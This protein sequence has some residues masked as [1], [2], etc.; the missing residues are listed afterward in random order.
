MICLIKKMRVGLIGEKLGHSFSK[1]I[2]EQL[3]SY[4]YDLI[5]LSQEEF[6]SFMKERLFDAINVTIPYKQAVIPYLDMMDEK[7]KKIGAVNAIKNVGGKLI[8]TNTDYDGLKLMIERHFNLENEVVLICGSGA[9]SKTAMAVVQ[10]LNPK[11]IIQVSRNPRD[12]MISYA[13][14]NQRKDITF[15][16]NTTSVG[17]S[18]KLNASVVDVTAFPCLKGV[19]D[20]VY[21]PLCTKLCYDASLLGIKAISGLEMLVGQAIVAIEFFLDQPMDLSIIQKL[22]REIEL[23]K[24]NKIIFENKE[25]IDCIELTDACQV[26]AASLMQGQTIFVNCQLDKEELMR[27]MLNGV[28]GV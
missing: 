10:D 20:V 24:R 13:Q 9:T 22:C 3:T 7:A 12:H 2:H 5:E 21:N 19:I 4:Q 1:E 11:E 23:K 15:I 6:H 8:G 14:V 27:L 28:V 16:I 18:P 26:E 17:M 25:N